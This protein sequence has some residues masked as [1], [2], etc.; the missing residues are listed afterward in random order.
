[1]AVLPDL[2]FHLSFLSF[3]L[4]VR[5]FVRYSES[6]ALPPR[7]MREEPQ[8]KHRNRSE[9]PVCCGSHDSDAKVDGKTREVHQLGDRS[10]FVTSA[11][12]TFETRLEK[13][14][15]DS[16]REF[17]IG[18]GLS[19]IARRKKLPGSCRRQEL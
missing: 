19:I 18:L 17:S 13:A 15:S 3:M 1:M 14:P 2:F 12:C 6:L 8:E 5:K 7:T 10:E 9:Y 4:S 11:S 16:V